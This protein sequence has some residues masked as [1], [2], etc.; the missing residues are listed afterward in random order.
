MYQETTT[1]AVTVRMAPQS[2]TTTLLRVVSILHSR[3]STVHQMDF[4]A[5][6][7]TGPL[8]TAQVSLTNAGRVTLQESLRRAAD[9]LDAFVSTS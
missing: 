2:D 8:L 5:D 7:P 6:Q 1:Y 4:D 9:V 3:R